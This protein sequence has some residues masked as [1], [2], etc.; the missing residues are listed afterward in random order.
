[1]KEDAITFFITRVLSAIA[2][3]WITLHGAEGSLVST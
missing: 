3:K 2:L 1:M